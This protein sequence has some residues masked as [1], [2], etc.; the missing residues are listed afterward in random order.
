LADQRSDPERPDTLGRDVRSMSMAAAMAADN[1][2]CYE[3]NGDTLPREHGYGTG[4]AAASPGA[5]GTST[6]ELP[7]VGASA[8]CHGR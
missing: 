8:A 2:L 4:T 7:A 5:S 3:M 1:L 6:G